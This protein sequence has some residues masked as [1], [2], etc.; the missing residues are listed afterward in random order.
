MTDSEHTTAKLARALEAIPGV[1]PPMIENARTGYYHDYLSPLD[2]PE[3]QL[4]KDLR[5]LAARPGTPRNS[6]PLLRDLA[7]AVT[8]GEYDASPAESA[9]WARSPEGQETIA[10]LT[11]AGQRSPDNDDAVIACVD[12]VGR[13]GATEFECGYLHEN[14]PVAEAGWYATAVYRGAKIIAADKASP[15]E[16]CDALAERLLSGAQCQHC[17]GLVALSD[18]GA[19]AY[20]SAVL[21]T[22]E[23]WDAEVAARAPQCRWT[24]TAGRWERGCE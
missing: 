9:E 14:V 8:A 3:L 18:A 4:I 24:R 7:K 10:A 17:H 2:A 19:F 21:A 11:G 5:E 1:P 20:R 6:R 23:R 22:G 13:S 15:A 12:L 16:A